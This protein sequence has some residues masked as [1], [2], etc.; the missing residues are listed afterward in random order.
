ML[1]NKLKIHLRW[2]RM[3]ASF[4]GTPVPLLMGI[5]GD[6]RRILFLRA[7]DKAPG[8]HG[9]ECFE[10]HLLLLSSSISS[11]WCQLQNDKNSL[12]EGLPVQLRCWLKKKLERNYML[13]CAWNFHSFV[14]YSRER[15]PPPPHQRFNSGIFCWESEKGRYKNSNP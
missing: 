2:L 1:Y 13:H 8:G 12:P 11:T 10:W 4:R 15:T 6:A 14:N 9:R 7:S 3:S 5:A